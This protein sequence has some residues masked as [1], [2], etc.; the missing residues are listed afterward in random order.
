MSSRSEQALAADCR[1]RPLFL[2]CMG[3]AIKRN[4][5]RIE[6]SLM[7]KLYK[8]EPDRVLYWEAWETDKEIIFHSGVLGERGKTRNVA[9]EAHEPSKIIADE[10]HKYRWFLDGS[11]VSRDSSRRSS[12][13]ARQYSLVHRCASLHLATA[14]SDI[15]HQQTSVRARSHYA[16]IDLGAD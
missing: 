4:V 16:A 11:S 12:R 8:F 13:L 1:E 10:A 7:I 6:R 15:N 5:R 9:V 3:E 14:L 2:N